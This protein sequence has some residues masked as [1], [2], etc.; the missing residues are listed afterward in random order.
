MKRRALIL[1]MATMAALAVPSAA[2]ATTFN[3]SCKFTDATF[4]FGAA[5]YAFGPGAAIGGCSGS[6]N[7]DDGGYFATLTS[8]GSGSFS[9]LGGSFSG[10][11]STLRFFDPSTRALVATL[12]LVDGGGTV[13]AGQVVRSV[14]GAVSGNA[15]ETGSATGGQSCGSGRYSSELRT[16]NGTLTD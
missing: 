6:L 13:L 9:C 3:G 5:G 4:S 12:D 8:A 2:Q 14:N 10:G 1:T 7:R 16:V 15:I 11:S